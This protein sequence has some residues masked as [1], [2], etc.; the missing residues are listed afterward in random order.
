MV[1]GIPA[2]LAYFQGNDHYIPDE[3]IDGTKDDFDVV[4][5]CTG[6]KIKH[7]FFDKEFLSFEEG[8]VPLLHRMIPAN[9]KNLNLDLDCFLGSASFGLR[10][11]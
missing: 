7:K 8:K 4:I 5:A 10:Y 11:L 2:L 1:K 9:I 6:F 3:F